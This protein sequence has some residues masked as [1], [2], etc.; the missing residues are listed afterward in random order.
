MQAKIFIKK[1]KLLDLVN[2]LAL[3]RQPSLSREIYRTKILKE[4]SCIHHIRSNRI[5]RDSDIF[6]FATLAG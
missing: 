2:A 5:I 6:R 1:I 3:R 4:L